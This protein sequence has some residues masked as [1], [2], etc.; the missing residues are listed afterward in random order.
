MVLMKILTGPN[1]AKVR[2]VSSTEDPSRLF[3]ELAERDWDWELDLSEA[4][5]DERFLWTREDIV[6]RCMR[7]IHCRYLPVFFM[8]KEY[9]DS[10]ELRQ[11]LAVSTR[12]I[13]M[14]TDD[15]T[16]VEISLGEY[17]Q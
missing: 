4:T 8:G 2:N 13:V 3:Q 9:N 15:D 10:K 1:R 17:P 5:D 14:V 7:A 12:Q 16:G 6:A 11:A